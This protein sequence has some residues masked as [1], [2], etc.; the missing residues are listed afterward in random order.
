M[1]AAVT[2]HASYFVLSIVQEDGT[3]YYLEKGEHSYY[4]IGYG[5]FSKA[6]KFNSED[7][8][9]NLIQTHPEFTKRNVY[10][11][12]TS[13]PPSI[14]WT[15]LGICND[16]PSAKGWFVIQ[17]VQPEI[18]GVIPVSDSLQRA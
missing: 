16:K 18:V 12:G 17:K 10:S 2:A 7:E 13:S 4:S 9:L 6:V 11:D 14:L 3:T 1:T 15:G 8:I 5:S